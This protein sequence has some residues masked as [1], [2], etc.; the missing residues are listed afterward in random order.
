VLPIGGLREKL[1][2]AVRSGGKRVILPEDNR[3]S[4]Y[5]V[6]DTVKQ[7][8]QI[9]FVRNVDRVIREALT[10]MPTPRAEILGKEIGAGIEYGT[11]CH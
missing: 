6:P 8:L 3:D 2:A 11:V 4:L 10:R 5:D 9:L 1:L 7:E